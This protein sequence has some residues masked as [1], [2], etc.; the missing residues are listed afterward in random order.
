[1][2]ALFRLEFGRIKGA[3]FI[4][5]MANKKIKPPAAVICSIEEAEISY[6][7]CKEELK[8]VRD[9]L[10]DSGTKLT[11]KR[12]GTRLH[13]VT[14]WDT[15]KFRLLGLMI[16]LRS[17]ERKT[18]DGYNHD[19][20][21]PIPKKKAWKSVDKRVRQ[22]YEIKC[23]KQETDHPDLW[24]FQKAEPLKAMWKRCVLWLTKKKLRARAEAHF[25]SFVAEREIAGGCVEYKLE[26]GYF[27]DPAN[28]RHRSDWIYLFEIEHKS[29]KKAAINAAIEELETALPFLKKRLQAT[30]KIVMAF[31]I[32]H[33]HNLLTKKKY[34]RS[35]LKARS[36][37]MEQMP[38]PE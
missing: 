5:I 20:K 25:Q 32:L 13:P 6:Q 27:S 28:G 8:Q 29:G 12:V 21:I 2:I 24:N 22:R 1:M 34:E 14:Y 26:V 36:R 9:M 35:Y 7:L 10:V 17:K 4:A 30:P 23:K 38:K 37:F 18:K 16:E 31:D 19:L 11:R 15:R 3:W 33:S